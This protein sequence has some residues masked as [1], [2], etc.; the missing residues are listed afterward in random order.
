MVKMSLEME[1][2]TMNKRL[3][4]CQSGKAS[5]EEEEHAETTKSLAADKTYLSELEQS[6]AA[7]V[8]EFDERQKQA[9]EEM[10]AV[11]KA[12]EILESGVSVFLQVSP[13][14]KLREIL[15]SGVSVFLQVSP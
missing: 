2:K 7:A 8:K 3:A 13:A 5:A 4:E 9:T 6:C 14:D 1:L 15:E 11:D 10:A 12:K